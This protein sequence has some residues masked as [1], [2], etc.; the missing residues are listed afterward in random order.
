[1]TSCLV[2][3]STVFKSVIVKLSH[4]CV[5]PSHKSRWDA[6]L[7]SWSGEDWGRSIL[8]YNAPRFGYLS[9]SKEDAGKTSWV[10]ESGIQRHLEGRYKFGSFQHSDA[11]K[12][13]FIRTISNI[14]KNR[15]ISILSPH[16]PSP[17]FNNYLFMTNPVSQSTP[18]L[19]PYPSNYF[20]ANSNHYIILFMNISVFS[21][22]E[23][24]C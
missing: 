11:I 4:I 5:N 18:H 6:S 8:E 20:E 13:N 22:R 3:L 2:H 16:K 23:T 9:E 17:N 21:K 15:G 12:K 1:M 7:H 14:L 24:P 10:F 19:P